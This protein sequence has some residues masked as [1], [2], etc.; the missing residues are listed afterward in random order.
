VGWRER[1]SWLLTDPATWRDLLWLTLDPTVIW[2]VLLI[3]GAVVVWGLIGVVMPL[4]WK[5]IVDHHGDN[6][7]AMIHV[8]SWTTAW[9]SVPLGVAFLVLG[10]GTGRLV[11]QGYFRWLRLLLAPTRRA[12]L[13]LRVRHLDASRTDVVEARAAEVYRIERDLHDGAQARLVSMGM[14]LSAAQHLMVD[15]P[16]AAEKLMAEAKEASARALT[17]LR[18]L[19]RGI[20]PPVLADRGLPDALRALALDSP[21]RVEVEGDLP[22]RL[23]APVES[24]GYFAACELMANVAK[25]ANAQRV[26]ID[27]R[28]EGGILHLG[29][30]DDGQGGAVLA[31]GTGLAGIERRLAAFD[32]ALV[33]SSPRNGPTIV[34]MEVP[35]ALSLPKTSS[36]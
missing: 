6:W 28:Y 33:L 20:H 29:V 2:C 4:V 10:A 32:G 17:E 14:M 27:I 34:T 26:W 24:A 11:I 3:P 25:H 5:P 15:D 7:Y 18:D 1:S 9:L 8:T 21:L 12:E 23:A 30:T 19:V 16:A 36:S 31:G 22:G 35:C 13:T